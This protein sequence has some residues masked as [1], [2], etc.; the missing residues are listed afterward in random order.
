MTFNTVS[1]L[2]PY[3]AVDTPNQYPI[4]IPMHTW[5]TLD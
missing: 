5:F 1:P 3:H 4:D 2:S